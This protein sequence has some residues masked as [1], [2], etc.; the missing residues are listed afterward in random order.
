MIILDSSCWLEYFLN[1]KHAD[2]YA[3]MIEEHGEVIVPAI[4]L[5]EVFK[6][7]MRVSGEDSALAVA[8]ILQQFPVIPVDENIAMF[9]AKIGQQFNL[10]MADSMILAT[11]Q[12]NNATLWS[13]DADF[14]G[15][16][17]VKYFSKQ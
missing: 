14:K 4:V 17:N 16:A 2:N 7:T 3:A 10:A 1:G 13:Q 11:A 6:V 12:I 5:H 8:G 9:S 15:L